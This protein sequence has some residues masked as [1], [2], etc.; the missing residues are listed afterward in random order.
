MESKVG[1]VPNE[2]IQYVI[3]QFE[4]DT[5]EVFVQN[6]LETR[7]KLQQMNLL[8]NLPPSLSVNICEFIH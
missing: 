4:D 8:D 1:S 2:L 5:N 3:A 6:V 7:K